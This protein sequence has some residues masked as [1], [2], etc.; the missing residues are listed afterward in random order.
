[1]AQVLE[2]VHQ[3]IDSAINWP[4]RFLNRDSYYEEVF[5]EDSEFNQEKFPTINSLFSE[6][7]EMQHQLKEKHKIKVE[8][9]NELSQRKRIEEESRAV[10]ISL[11]EQLANSNAER[12]L[13]LEKLEHGDKERNKIEEDFRTARIALEEQL[14]NYNAEKELITNKLRHQRQTL[15]Q[16]LDNLQE[17]FNTLSDLTADD[18]RSL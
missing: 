1:M 14:A 5:M 9:E 17:R 15:K 13:L 11:E 6:I 8:L 10:K 2:A 18:F 3:E 16:A 7:A 4:Q 12:G